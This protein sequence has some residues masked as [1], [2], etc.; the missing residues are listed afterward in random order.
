MT[1]DATSAA[2]APR[3]WLVFTALRLVVFV[4]TAGFF[5]I[6]GL[7]GF[8][9]LLIALPVSAAISFVV[10]KRQRQAVV[11]VQLARREHKAAQRE[12]MRTRLDGG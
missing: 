12:A 3:A 11:A 4:G 8:P 7:N 10:L 2:P 5:A 1:D 6:F 9:L